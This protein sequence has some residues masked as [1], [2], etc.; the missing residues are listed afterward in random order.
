M[1]DEVIDISFVVGKKGVNVGLIELTSTL[2]LGKNKVREE[3]QS[4]VC[5]EGEPIWCQRISRDKNTERRLDESEEE[6]K[7][8]DQERIN[9]VQDSTREKQDRTTQ[10]MS[11]GVSCAGSDVRRAL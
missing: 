2:S 5:I 4:K 3:N 1:C 6:R 8:A 11:H 9:Q 7:Q 10:Y